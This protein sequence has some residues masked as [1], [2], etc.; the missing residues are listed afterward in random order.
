MR[1]YFHIMKDRERLR[2]PDGEEFASLACAREEATQ[3]ARG[4]QSCLRAASTEW[5]SV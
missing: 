2:D 4:T 5:L 1:Y 3:C